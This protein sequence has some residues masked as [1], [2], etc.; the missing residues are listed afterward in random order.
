MSWIIRNAKADDEQ[1][2]LGLIN[3]ESKQSNIV[4]R[5]RIDWQNF[6]V[7]MIKDE[8]V[9]CVG[10]KV[11]DSILPE[12]I[13]TIVIPKYRGKIKIA[14]PMVWKLLSNLKKRGF[15]SVFCL[16]TRQDFFEKFGM[17]IVPVKVFPQKILA[18][19]QFCPRNLGGP[20]NPKCDDI[21]LFREL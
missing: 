8:I 10:Y 5:D 19:C 14:K 9:S 2:I 18:D 13:S 11:W 7:G 6:V 12:I 15:H 16:T 17:Q 21:A 1:L 3:Q 4:P 20:H